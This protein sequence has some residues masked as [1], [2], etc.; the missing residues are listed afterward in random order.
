MTE[1]KEVKWYWYIIT[2]T[3]GFVAGQ[4]LQIILNLILK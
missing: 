1:P 2:G 4:L 3:I